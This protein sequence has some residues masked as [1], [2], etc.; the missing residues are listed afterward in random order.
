MRFT[1]AAAWLVLSALGSAIPSER[2]SPVQGQS[3]DSLLAGAG[4]IK[5]DLMAGGSAINQQI[6]QA[7]QQTEQFKK[8]N[9]T[10]LQVRQEW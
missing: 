2:S 6:Y 4:S 9:S 10:N 1:L 7:T 5:Q 3:S 8:C